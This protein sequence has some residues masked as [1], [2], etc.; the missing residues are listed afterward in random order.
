MER[1]GAQVARRKL[2]LPF[3]DPDGRGENEGRMHDP[4][5]SEPEGESLPAAAPPPAY[6]GYDP[7]PPPKKPLRTAGG[8]MAAAA[9]L[10]V[11]FKGVLLLL[12]N[13][14]WL[15]LVPKLALSFGS[16][17]LS[18]WLY[19]VF[20]GWK[21]GVVFVLLILVH[22][23]G[24]YLTF[25]NFGIQANLPFFIPGLGAFVAT[26][27][28]VKSLTV[29]AIATLAGPVF[30]IGAAAICFG[31]AVATHQPFWYAAAY[32]GF[33]LNALNLLPIPP[34]DGGGIAGAIDPRLW[35]LGVFGFLAFLI[36][37]G[38]W[39]SFTIIMVAIVALGAIP[40]ISA[41]LKGRV[42]PRLA[43]V[44]IASRW[45]LALAYFVV[46]AVAVA[47]AV[48]AHLDVGTLHA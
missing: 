7:G 10:F 6:R 29:E 12:L 43:D 23:L 42:D 41:L 46:I 13:L 40:R 30:G 31:Y 48:V 39:T 18:I 9:L 28:P 5:P 27:G 4:R 34:F 14:K 17:F 44:P 25:R 45:G 21:F 8:V 20:F 47:G 35:I 1:D 37:F 16:L 3:A 38:V 26:R 11:K 33:F 36:F 2:R 22:E 19:A 15:V 32:V 24:H